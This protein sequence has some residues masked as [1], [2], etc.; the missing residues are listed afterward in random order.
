MP[1]SKKNTKKDVVAKEETQVAVHQP[2]SPL[3]VL[4]SDT[5]KLKEFPI[6]TVERLFVL[7]QQYRAEKAKIAFSVAFNALQ[8]DISPVVKRGKNYGVKQGGKSF[9]PY[10][11]LED[12]KDVVDPLFSK[13]GFSYSIS[14]KESPTPEYTRYILVLRHVSGYSEEHYLDAP[15]DDIGMKGGATKTKIH[16]QGSSYTYCHRYLL[17]NV[18][19][20]QLIEDDDGNASSGV[21]PSSEAISEDQ[22]R[23]ILSLLAET[24][25]D[26]KEFLDYFK[27]DTVAELRVGDYQKVI[28][29]LHERKKKAEQQVAEEAQRATEE[30]QGA[31]E[32]EERAEAEDSKEKGSLL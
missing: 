18:L 19:G 14:A 13:H 1:Q 22:E 5:E 15:T 3:E 16:G 21:G 28:N 12:I 24:K 4:L 32:N 25:T 8:T 17:Q 29:L 7:D 27:R 23:E 9:S 20:M 2:P 26:T 10:A 6:E 30:A 31:A 11:R